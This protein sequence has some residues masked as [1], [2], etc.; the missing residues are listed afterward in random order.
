MQRALATE[1]ALH[2]KL[3]GP[4]PQLQAFPALLYPGKLQLGLLADHL[5]LCKA[6][7]PSEVTELRC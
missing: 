4:L 7:N 1:G 3:P 6:D 2:Q 5:L